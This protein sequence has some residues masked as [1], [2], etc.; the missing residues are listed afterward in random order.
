M[1]PAIRR[2]TG[3]STTNAIEE[4]AMSRPRSIA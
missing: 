2:R 3:D 1:T 4:I